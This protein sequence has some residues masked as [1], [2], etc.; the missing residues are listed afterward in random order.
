MR[1]DKQAI[2]RIFEAKARL[3]QK[4][5]Q[6]PLREKIE[7]VVQMQIRADKLSRARGGPGRVVWNVRS[8]SSTSS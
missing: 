8:K 3:R 4:L 6:L 7:H 2:D 1:F 5:A